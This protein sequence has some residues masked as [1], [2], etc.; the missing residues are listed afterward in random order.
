M[1]I[2]EIKISNELMDALYFKFFKREEINLQRRV[3]NI[4][5][6]LENSYSLS[7]NE[8]PMLNVEVKSEIGI[9]KKD[10]I[11]F[12]KLYCKNIACSK[13]IDY[14]YFSLASENSINDLQVYLRQFSYD[15][16]ITGEDLD[17]KTRWAVRTEDKYIFYN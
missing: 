9:T 2:R 12:M 14:P 8:I 4:K 3:E 1:K 13:I 5:Y 16:E 11:K 17:C 15:S 7:W 6:H 10:A